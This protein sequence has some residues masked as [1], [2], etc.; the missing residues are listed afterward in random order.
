VEVQYGSGHTNHLSTFK[1]T[2]ERKS[3]ELNSEKYF[4]YWMGNK[5]RITSD[6]PNYY[7]IRHVN[8]RAG[9]EKG[10][11]RNECVTTL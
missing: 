6:F 2:A 8:V 4:C 7:D 9:P 11:F 5:P 10:R 3:G 1:N